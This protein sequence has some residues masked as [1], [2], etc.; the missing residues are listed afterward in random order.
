MLLNIGK[1]QRLN[2][3]QED[4]DAQDKIILR[5]NRG[6]ENSSVMIKVEVTKGNAV[7]EKYFKINI[8]KL[9][10]ELLPV[11]IEKAEPPKTVAQS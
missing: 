5:V 7:A 11:T 9:D 1:G 6:N 4:K 2:K 8:P 10:T 3:E